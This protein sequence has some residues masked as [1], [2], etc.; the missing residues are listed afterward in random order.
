MQ[1]GPL[2]LTALLAALDWGAWDWASNTGHTTIG[3]AAGV[4]LVPALLALA[5]FLLVNA[6]GLTRTGI[7]RASAR[8]HNHAPSASADAAPVSANDA[9]AAPAAPRSRIAA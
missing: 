3:L 8:R 4:L 9:P 2:G 5:W 1:L 6:L 7:Q